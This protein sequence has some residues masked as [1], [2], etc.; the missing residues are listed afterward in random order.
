MWIVGAR[1]YVKKLLPVAN[2][3]K[4]QRGRVNVGG[5]IPYSKAGVFEVAA[6][7]C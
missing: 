7:S 1:V 5:E 2:S 3:E 6:D 4:V